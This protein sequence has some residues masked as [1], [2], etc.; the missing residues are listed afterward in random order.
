MSDEDGLP[1]GGACD[2]CS[3]VVGVENRPALDQLLVALD[4]GES[5]DDPRGH[6]MSV[7][8]TPD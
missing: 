8:R 5:C 1:Y 6:S 2:R 3:L 7:A 4:G